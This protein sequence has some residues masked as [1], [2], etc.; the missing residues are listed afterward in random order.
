[1][2]IELM[3]FFKKIFKHV[4]KNLEKK[5]KKLEKVQMHEGHARHVSLGGTVARPF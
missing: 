1:M 2:T 5:K 3:Y 4:I